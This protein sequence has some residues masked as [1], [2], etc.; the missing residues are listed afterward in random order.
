MGTPTDAALIAEARTTPA[1][2]EAVVHRHHLAVHRYV[3]RR[4][5]PTDAEDV[6][7]EVFATA[8]AARAR[9]DGTR[10]DA[11]PWLFGIATN[12]VRRHHRKEAEIL[13]A[14][15]RSGTDPV[16]PEAPVR[17]P[18]LSKALAA[19]LAGMRKEH[20]DV[21]LLHAIVDLSHEEIGVALGVPVGTVKGWLHRARTVAA[22]ELAA[23]GVLPVPDTEPS[24]TEAMER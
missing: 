8:Y 2:F 21:L 4:L 18:A 9:Y 6:V 7:S 20:R 22:R 12:L 19:A 17:D 10:A 5:G 1:A 16:A 23:R 11:R 3:A 24:P 15:A 13:A 14:Y